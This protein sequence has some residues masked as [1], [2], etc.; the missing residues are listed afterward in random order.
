MAASCSGARLKFPLLPP[1]Q[2]IYSQLEFPSPCDFDEV[3][4][5]RSQVNFLAFFFPVILLYLV[6]NPFLIFLFMDDRHKFIYLVMKDQ[7]KCI[8]LVVAIVL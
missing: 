2:A 1:R 3:L 6:C 8:Y 5:G 7:D 4:I